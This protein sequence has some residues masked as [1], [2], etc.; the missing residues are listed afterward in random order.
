MSTKNPD[1]NNENLGKLIQRLRQSAK[2][3]LGGLAEQ[4]G[5]SKS[6]ISQIERNESNPTLSTIRK[7]SNALETDINNL[8]SPDRKQIFVS[9]LTNNATPLIRSEDGLF[10]LRVLGSI[11]TVD[12]VQWYHVTAKPGGVLESEGHQP[13]SLE[14]LTMLG[15]EITVEINGEKKSVATGETL[16]YKADA[17][18]VLRNESTQEA[19]ALMVLIFI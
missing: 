1:N 3:S 14:H 6:I 12:F 9:K 2:L 7:L 18:H 13:G 4:S 5:V 8:I 10:D 19:T 17:N 16:R 11:E 15:G